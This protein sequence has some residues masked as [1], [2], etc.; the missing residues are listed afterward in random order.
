M[1][2]KRKWAS[3]REAANAKSQIVLQFFFGGFALCFPKRN[4]HLFYQ[5]SNCSAILLWGINISAALLLWG[6]RK[7]LL[8]EESTFLF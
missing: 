5:K 7:A 8:S 6:E 1:R 2:S 3:V 4:Q